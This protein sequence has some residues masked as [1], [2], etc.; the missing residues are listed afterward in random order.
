MGPESGAGSIREP[1]MFSTAVA[2]LLADGHAAFVE[3]SAHPILLPAIQ[4]ELQHLGRE[5]A[6]LPSLRREEDE[7]ATMLES[8]GALHALGSD[9]AWNALFPTGG[10]RPRL[11]SYPRQPERFWDD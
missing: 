10:H 6:V 5:G 11:P 9:G 2:K 3:L 8:L 7:Q 4:Q 1:V